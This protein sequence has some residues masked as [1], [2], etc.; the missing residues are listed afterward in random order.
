[1]DVAVAGEVVGLVVGCAGAGL[2]IAR[3]AATDMPMWMRMTLLPFK[4]K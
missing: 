3:I 4:R 2:A 1:L